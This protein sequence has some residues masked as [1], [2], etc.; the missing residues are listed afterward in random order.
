MDKLKYTDAY[1]YGLEKMLE[2]AQ[3]E[4][5]ELSARIVSM[6]RTE[7]ALRESKEGQANG[8]RLCFAAGGRGAGAAWAAGGRWNY[9]R[10]GEKG[11]A[12]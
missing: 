8:R 12:A 7:Q 11:L 2:A 10:F 6:A 5:A 9:K 4:I 3:R 1:I